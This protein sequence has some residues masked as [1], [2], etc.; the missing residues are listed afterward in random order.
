[1]RTFAFNRGYASCVWPLFHPITDLLMNFRF[2]FFLLVHTPFFVHAQIT[3]GKFT[4]AGFMFGTVNYSGDVA[5]RNVEWKESRL[6]Y[7]FFV[8]HHFNPHLAVRAHVYSGTISGD[9]ANTTKAARSYRFSA[10]IFEGA[11][12]GEWTLFPHDK[13]TKTGIFTPRMRPYLFAG[14]GYTNAQPRAEYYGPEDKR[15]EF[16]RIPLPEEDLRTRFLMAP[17][18]LG[19]RA[20]VNEYFLIG[21]DGGFRPVYSDD[22]DGMKVNGNPDKNDWYYFFGLTFS[23]ILGG[24]H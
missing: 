4:E 22:L 10:A 18:G 17:F 21:F 6:A 1:L 13:V 3:K 5:E 15:N 7:G 19:I 8:R 12:V 14:V 24:N 20:D 23:V 16:L 9:D 11:V 2:L